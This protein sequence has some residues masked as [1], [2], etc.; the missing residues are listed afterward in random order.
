MLARQNPVM[1]FTSLNHYLDYEWLYY[2]YELTRKDG[3]V[4]VDGQTAAEYAERL[5]ES[6]HR[7]LHQLKSGT[8]HAPPVWCAY[9]KPIII[10]RL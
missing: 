4:G 7:L 8:S 6:L 5:E 10:D 3:V 9:S 2:A 1:A